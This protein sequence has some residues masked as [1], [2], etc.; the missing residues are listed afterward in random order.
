MIVVL[1][2]KLMLGEMMGCRPPH[3]H[4]ASKCQISYI[5]INLFIYFWLCWVFVVAC[6]LSLVLASRSY[7]SLRCVG[8]S[9][10]WLLFVAEHGP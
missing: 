5:Y 8:F 6:G 10:L 3:D 1:M 7:S 9:L 4:T 2:W